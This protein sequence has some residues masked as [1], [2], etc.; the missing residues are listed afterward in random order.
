MAL[1]MA[2]Y[3]VLFVEESTENLEEF[4]RS[5]LVLEKDPTRAE[6]IDSIFRC[7]HSIK[8]MAASLDYASITSV[9]HSLEDRMQAFRSAGYV[10]P[11][12]E[13]SLLFRG[14]AALESMVAVV[15]DTHEP[16]PLDPD[17]EQVLAAPI[18]PST[19]SSEA[20]AQAAEEQTD[21]KKK[22]QIP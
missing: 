12:D 3:R 2:K 10:P 5:L 9:A 18:N 13:M 21:A 11:G 4:S 22:V 19:S 1:D 16:P 20:Y 15:R 8:G 7:A 14:L 6:A 17:L